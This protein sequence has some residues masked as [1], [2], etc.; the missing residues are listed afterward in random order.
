MSNPISDF[1]DVIWTF[2]KGNETIDALFSGELSLD[3]YAEMLYNKRREYDACVLECCM[4]V[5][6]RYD[7]SFFFERLAPQ[8]SKYSNYDFNKQVEEGTRE[9]WEL[10]YH[11][12]RYKELSTAIKNTKDLMS[13][14][15]VTFARHTIVKNEPLNKCEEEYIGYNFYFRG[16]Y[17][18]EQLKVI[19]DHLLYRYLHNATLFDDFVYYMTGRGNKIPTERMVWVKDNVD[20]AHFIDAFFSE[21]N[22]RW[23]IA[24]MIFGKKRLAS[25]Y[26]QTPQE[27]PFKQFKKDKVDILKI[28]R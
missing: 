25:A 21:H 10:E 11:K 19:Y 15:G 20:L 14:S 6:D 1:Y 26:Y 4:N 27:N 24:E 18:D 23:K 17:T 2:R 7:L 16:L 22:K 8:L 5:S 28:C 3:S 9:Y 12:V 13:S